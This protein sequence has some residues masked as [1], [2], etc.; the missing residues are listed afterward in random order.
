MPGHEEKSIPPSSLPAPFQ[1]RNATE[2]QYLGVLAKAATHYPEGAP[3]A[4]GIPLLV[5]HPAVSRVIVLLLGPP[6]GGSVEL[7]WAV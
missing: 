4:T 1:C 2:P 6:L 3:C 5:P 7:H